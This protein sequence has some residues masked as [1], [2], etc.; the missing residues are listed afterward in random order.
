MAWGPRTAERCRVHSASAS[1]HHKAA[2]SVTVSRRAMT[3]RSLLPR[4]DGVPSTD[5]ESARLRGSQAAA[6]LARLRTPSSGC[7]LPHHQKPRQ[8]RPTL[9]GATPSGARHRW[10]N[11]GSAIPCGWRRGRGQGGRCRPGLKA[12][13]ATAPPK[14]CAP[15]CTDAAP[16]DTR[17]AR[18]HRARPPLRERTMWMVAPASILLASIVAPS[19]LEGRGARVKTRCA[20]DRATRA[21]RSPLS[22][23]HTRPPRPPPCTARRTAACPSGSGGSA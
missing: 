20:S 2:V 15:M 6:E 7:A 10:R 18:A 22:R 11:Q 9:G 16:L 19:S 17:A 21:A 8:R 1:A 5:T 23:P 12:P 3:R 14:G 13:A 4:R